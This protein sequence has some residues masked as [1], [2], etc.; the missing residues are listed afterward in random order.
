MQQNVVILAKWMA[1][2]TVGQ[3]NPLQ[4]R[5]PGEFD[6]EHVVD[7][8]FEPVGGGPDFAEAGGP[9]VF[10]KRNFQA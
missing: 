4:V 2:P 5:M 3:E 8:A 9:F 6:A 7:F 1:L 10:G